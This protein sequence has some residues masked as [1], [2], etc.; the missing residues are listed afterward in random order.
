MG[1][2]FCEYRERAYGTLDVSINAEYKSMSIR[3][4]E[5]E[6]F[7]Q[8]ATN[9]LVQNGKIPAERKFAGLPPDFL[10]SKGIQNILKQSVSAVANFEQSKDRCLLECEIGIHMFRVHCSSAAANSPA[11]EGRHQDGFKYISVSVL[12]R[13]RVQGGESIVAR[14][15]D[16]PAVLSKQLLPGEGL[17]FDDKLYYHDVTEIFPSDECLKGHRDVLVVTFTTK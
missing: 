11:P 16:G 15:L 7:K 10:K 13:C 2:K 14:T 5:H 1:D 3:R 6:T 8:G 17:V 4:R 9:P 12:D